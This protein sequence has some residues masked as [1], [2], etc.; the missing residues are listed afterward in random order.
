MLDLTT[1]K[2]D[3]SELQK[4]D[5]QVGFQTALTGA[6]TISNNNSMN[7]SAL[8]SP[9]P[10]PR[11]VSQEDQMNKITKLNPDSMP[12]CPQMLPPQLAQQQALYQQQLIQVCP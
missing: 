7:S 8:Q 1:D 9:L 6:A 10:P 4:Q 12:F 3:N 2:P 5:E 11:Q